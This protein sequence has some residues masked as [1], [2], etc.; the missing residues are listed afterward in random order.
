MYRQI[1]DK[2]VEPGLYLCKKTGKGIFVNKDRTYQIGKTKIKKDCYLYFQFRDGKKV[3]QM[4]L[5][6]T[7]PSHWLSDY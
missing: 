3:I 4:Y 6:K 5:G 1:L 2:R 7:K